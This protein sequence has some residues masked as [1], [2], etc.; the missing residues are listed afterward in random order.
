MAAS[1]E[2]FLQNCPD[3]NTHA[4]L[5]FRIM[6]FKSKT[7]YPFA[8]YLSFAGVLFM[9]TGLFFFRQIAGI[10][11][12][13]AGAFLCFTTSGVVIDTDSQ[14]MKSFSRLFGIVSVGKWMDYSNCTGIAIVP[15]TTTYVV[16]SRSDR[17]NAL[18]S[19][20]YRVYLVDKQLKPLCR[21]GK[22]KTIQVAK[23]EV[24]K[25]SQLLKL[26]ECTTHFRI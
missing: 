1:L 12:I 5:I 16:H 11:L 22:F 25:L 21:L 14:R 6:K 20:F 8:P 7:E 17:T 26:P 9:L 3:V 23:K 15:V 18:E 2:I 4:L 19:R 13:A 10:V 24:E